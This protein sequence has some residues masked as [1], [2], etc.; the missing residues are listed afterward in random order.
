MPGSANN[1]D[2]LKA[3]F[4]GLTNGFAHVGLAQVFAMFGLG[5]PFA[6]NLGPHA[7]HGLLNGGE[8]SR[9]VAIAAFLD[10]LIPPR[11]AIAVTG[12]T[13]KPVERIGGDVF[14]AWVGLVKY[15]GRGGRAQRQVMHLRQIH[16]LHWNATLKTETQRLPLG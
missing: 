12:G 1:G 3:V 2:A 7:R 6:R 8:K 4:F 11:L 14:G 13:T 5:C 15:V 10:H 16:E 9:A